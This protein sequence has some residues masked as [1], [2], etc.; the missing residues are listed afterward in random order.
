MERVS[1]ITGAIGKPNAL[2]NYIMQLQWEDGSTGSSRKKRKLDPSSLNKSQVEF[3]ISLTTVDQSTIVELINILVQCNEQ[4]LYIQWDYSKLD[5]I[6]NA[7]MRV[8]SECT[9]ECI[10]ENDC[11]IM[12]DQFNLQTTKTLITDT[13]LFVAMVFGAHSSWLT[14]SNV[15]LFASA[16]KLSLNLKFDFDLDMKMAKFG[17][18]ENIA[19]AI[20]HRIPVKKPTF[21]AEQS[22]RTMSEENAFT[23]LMTPPVSTTTTPSLSNTASPSRS[24]PVSS[25]TNISTPASTSNTPSSSTAAS[26]STNGSVP[27]YSNFSTPSTPTDTSLVSFYDNLQ[28]AVSEKYLKNYASSEMVAKLRPFQTQNVEWMVNREGHMAIKNGNVCVNQKIMS[29][30]PLLFSGWRSNGGYRNLFTDEIVTERSKI[31]KL[32]KRSFKGGILAD[33]MGLGKTVR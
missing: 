11:C 5:T 20:L 27:S 33:E 26:P 19:N 31:D 3:P 29:S 12:S 15:K 8:V 25:R 16:D 10:L 13:Q 2:A 21:E 17:N 23:R 18:A 4:K 32:I 1:T 30:S 7:T 24:D 22:N 6:I 28:P 9:G 14:V